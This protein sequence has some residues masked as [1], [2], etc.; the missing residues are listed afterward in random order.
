MR[1]GSLF[2]GI[3]GIELGFEAEG[4]ETV[5]F[6]EKDP[7]AQAVLKQHWPGT[8]IYDDVTTVD[9]STVPTVD[10]IVGGFPCQDISNA[11]KRVG[12]TGSRSGLWTYCCEAIR[13]LRPRIAFFENVAAIID[14]GLDVVLSDLATLG[15]DAE[16]HCLPA[17]AIGAPHRRD[18]IIIIAYP[19]NNGQHK[20]RHDQAPRQSSFSEEREA[21][22]L[23]QR[24]E[25]INETRRPS[26]NVADTDGRSL[27][28]R[29]TEQE[30]QLNASR[31]GVQTRESRRSD[32]W[33]TEPNVG[34]MAHGIPYRVDRI[35]CL[36]NAVVPGWAQVVAA[37]IKE[38][39]EA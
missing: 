3:G 26:T 18:R 36:G 27:A 1:V 2:S 34:R 38:T 12:I 35:K 11:G 33:H 22:F 5:W 14:R 39:E 29:K 30:F 17:A 6:V 24:S 16:W 31:H 15:Y 25:R 7:Y 9:F 23:S 32:T 4:F 21:A 28:I 19:N 37:A 8:K 20:Q 10:V 13:S